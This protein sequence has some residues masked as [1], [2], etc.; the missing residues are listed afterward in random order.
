MNKI[1]KRACAVLAVL[2]VAAGGMTAPALAENETTDGSGQVTAFKGAEGGGMYTKGA[3]AALDND[4]K[5]E[6][7][8]VTNLNNSGDGS[9]RDA[10][11]KGNRIVVFDVSGYVDLDSNVTIGHDNITIL[12]Q[13]APGDG[14]CFR[15][16]NI[17]VGANNVI[18]RY[19]RFRVGAHD[20]N[21]NDTR[22]QDGLEVT[23]NCQNVIIDH[24]SVSWGTDENL[25]AY[26]V[27]DVTIQNSII[28]ESL[29]QSVH[30]KG[31]HSYAAIWGGVNLTVHH[32]IIATHKSRNPK[33]GTSE[34]VSMTAGYTDDQTLVDI[35]NNIIYNWGDKA[36]YG[37]ENGAKTYIQNNI[38]RPGPATPAGKRA[39]IFELSIGNK[40]ETNMLGSVYAK[41]N[42]ID[43]EQDDPDYAAAQSVNEEN[44]QNDAHTGVYVD[45]KY[46][47]IA[48]DTNAKIEIPDA[49]YQ[50]YEAEYPVTLDA[51]EDVF[52]KVIANA[53]ATL[54][55][56][57]EVDTRIVNDV[58][59]R[60]AP[61]G[62]KGSVGL[63]DDPTDIDIFDGRGY[64]EMEAVTRAVADYDTDAD[65]IPDEWEDKMGLDKANPTDGTQIGPDGYTWL[66]IYVEEAITN[67]KPDDAVTVS[68]M[69]DNA[70]VYKDNEE[71]PLTASVGRDTFIS[72]YEDGVVHIVPGSGFT[73]GCVAVVCGYTDGALSAV[74]YGAVKYEISDCTADV[75]EV[76]GDT[77]R[78]F[79]WDSLEGMKPLCGAYPGSSAPQAAAKVEFYCDDALIGEAQQQ[80]DGGLWIC[81]T[82]L[83]SGDHT[84]TA[85]AAKTD[86][87]YALSP[88]Q[89]ISVTGSQAAENWN[90]AGGAGFDGSNYTLPNNSSLT[91]TVSGDFK[92]VTKTDSI[93]S[94]FSSVETGLKCGGITIYKSY[95]SDFNQKTGYNL[96]DGSEGNYTE[97]SADSCKYLEISRTGS[98]VSLYAGTSL[99]DLENNK[100][101]EATVSGSTEVGAY[102]SGDES[103]ITV[104][105]LEMLCLSTVQTSPQAELQLTAGQ[106]L[107]L[108]GETVDVT[109]TPDGS[110]ITEVWLYL[111]GRPLA[112]KTGLSISGKETVSI[113][114]TF[115]TP[116]NGTITAYCFDENL[117]KGTAS[118]DVAITQDVTPWELTDI[119]ASDTDVKSYVLGTTDYTYKIGDSSDGQIGG[120]EDRFAFL[121]QQFTGNTRLYARL[122]LQSAEQIGFVL[123]NDL[124][125]DSITYYFGANMVDGAVKYQLTKRD[126]PGGETE[127][128]SD[129]TDIINDNSKA[130]IVA[131]KNGNNFNIYKTTND[132][133]LYKVNTLIASVDC[134]DI[135]DTYYMGFGAVSD[136]ELIPD[137]G[138]L[139]IESMND[140]GTT[141]SWSFDN[142]LDWLWQLQEAN[143]LTP[144]WTDE[145]IAGNATGKMKI[146]TG[147]DYT[148]ER[149][150]FH[151]Y[152]PGDGNKVVNAQ[153]D[154]LVSG[155][156]AG[157]NVYLTAN[158]SDSGFKVS[159]ET[160][161]YIYV[162][163][164]KTDY[165]YDINKWYT[166]L[167]SVDEGI[168]AAAAAIIVKDADGTIIA[169]I[170]EAEAADFRAQNNVE[171]KVPVTNGIFF[172]P[173]ANKTGAY[174][175]DNVSVDVTDS[176]IQKTVL[177]G[178]F[179]NF[180][181]SEEF[182]NLTALVNGEEYAGLHVI[183]GA[184]IEA[185]SKTIDGI[186]FSK[187]YKMG[188]AGS[189]TSK[190]VYFDVPA[191][192]T[193]IVVYGEPAGSS[194]TRSIVI[195][196]GETHATVVTTQT[197]VYYTHDG[198]AARIYVY[199][200]AGINLYG[201]S[202]ETYTY[203]EQ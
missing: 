32:N 144:S 88:A 74:K 163:G 24:C 11:S 102:V 46:Y 170:P 95:N 72:G 184:A 48:D 91:Q 80:E 140:A 180:G 34:T 8:H 28:A 43:V 73:T 17:K 14:I 67:P 45:S 181:S 51:A 123:K 134:D 133:N 47:G 141:S 65:G 106:R 104:S 77:V 36:G 201:I 146:A 117:G 53:G 70:V 16:N 136:G 96:G 148:G 183:G 30:D 94:R 191:G 92:L 85:K 130:Y 137:I 107:L 60:T 81:N 162:G 68:C 111:D 203:D 189:R 97:I 159:F 101:G 55:K 6:V 197:A 154:V 188:G 119:G 161:G 41:G 64:P 164:D 139:G 3:R 131:E 4:E 194:G 152:V 63:L 125:T 84:I 182:D 168:N 147:S 93:T 44:W 18:L 179:W 173:I 76:T 110:P 69:L 202:Y 54:P 174:Y 39:R 138:W 71:I 19:V 13:T 145:E 186:S 166:V 33:I 52:D 27:K 158:S 113:P 116:E 177:A 142:G 135:N 50:T 192:T 9:F 149:Y 12:G 151:E 126:T 78:I 57:D 103:N 7:Y 38:Y 59:N 58:I 198:D 132:A 87:T 29:N 79:V 99:A 83:P 200:D 143:M 109:V 127:L 121:N 100:V 112:S 171:K 2:S 124:D 176:S 175:I 40:Y 122:R 193:D 153:A 37:S 31:E 23:D 26:A 169:D 15:S 20:K 86:G 187:R 5:I 190:C 108:T 21:G 128:V 195:D 157:I 199:G 49:V 114:V 56:R 61:T 22:A 196:D 89:Y 167:Y 98:T 82:Y 10:V 35:K 25:S 62:S 178:H 75:G 165:T 129:V 160:D 172:E 105:K 156:D 66:E 1:L 155:D 120:T 42:I 90:A 150:I 115:T 118:V 185:N